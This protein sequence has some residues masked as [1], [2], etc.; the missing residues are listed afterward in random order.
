MQKIVLASKNKGKI[1]EIADMLHELQPGL[2]VLGLSD[3]PEIGSLPETGQ[4]FAENALQ[5]A[6]AVA[7]ATGLV[8]L[9]DDSGLEVDALQGAPGVYS[10]RYSG[11]GA[12]DE[13]NN[14][15]LLKEMAEVPDSSRQARFVCVLIAY[16][17]SGVIAR[18]DGRWEGFVAKSPRGKAGFG[19]DPL[20]IDKQTGLTAAELE[21]EQKNKRSHRGKAL[22]ALLKT[23]PD[24]CERVKSSGK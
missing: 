19:Y 13:S 22:E 24:F 2:E 20:F 8:A 18:A 9:A 5:K 1:A 3:F 21:P 14:E 15:K 11:K 6:T 12:T 10:A 4:S 23:W 7:R 17:P 16:A